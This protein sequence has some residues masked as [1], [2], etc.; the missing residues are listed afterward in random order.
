M[1]RWPCRA[2]RH[3]HVERQHREPGQRQVELCHIDIIKGQP[4]QR[5]QRL[6]LPCS[7]AGIL[8]GCLALSRACQLHS[9]KLNECE[10]FQ[11]RRQ[12]L[13][14]P[15]VEICILVPLIAD[16]SSLLSLDCQAQPPQA[17]KAPKA[18][19]IFIQCPKGSCQ[20]E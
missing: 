13:Q 15:W 14:Q 1:Q 6:R 5:C 17:G 12:V 16:V 9:V 18:H 3:N 4:P 11:L 2:D 20:V 10:A 19:H 8:A 7:T